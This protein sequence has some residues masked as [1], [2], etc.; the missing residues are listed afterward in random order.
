[1]S[2]VTCYGVCS[3]LSMSVSTSYQAWVHL[4]PSLYSLLT[5]SVVTSY[6][7]C[8]HLLSGLCHLSLCLYSPLTR[9]VV[10][11]FTWSVFTYLQICITSDQ[12]YT[13]LPPCSSPCL[14]SLLSSSY[15]T[16]L[17]VF[18][19]S[20]SYIPLLPGLYSPFTFCIHYFYCIRHLSRVLRIKRF[21]V[22]AF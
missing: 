20:Q 12:V 19:T 13:Q 8:S 18:S 6:Q 10:T 9:S 11:P 1:M 16:Q 15:T 4:S 7:V 17:S 2:V 22:L 21:K 5:R 14:Y 3:S